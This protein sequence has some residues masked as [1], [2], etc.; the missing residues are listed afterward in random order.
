MQVLFLSSTPILL[1]CT[2]DIHFVRCSL[3]VLIFLDL[4]DAYDTVD[5]ILLLTT[6][7]SLS[8]SP[9]LISC[10]FLISS[11]LLDKSRA[12]FCKAFSILPVCIYACYL[13]QRNAF[14]YA[15]HIATFQKFKILSQTSPLNSRHISRS[16]S[17]MFP[18]RSN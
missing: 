9:Y 3:F 15:T 10:S 18:H 11:A 1:S 8:S 7:S 17:G 14:K 12:S 16:F 5:K 13:K 2:R 4:L 6:R